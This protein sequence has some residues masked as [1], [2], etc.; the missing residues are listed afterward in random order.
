MHDSGRLVNPMLAEG[1]VVGGGAQGLGIALLEEVAYDP[2]SGRPRAAT[3][4]ADYQLPTARDVPPVVVEHRCTPSEV[5]PGGYRGV[6][7]GGILPPPATV[8]AAVAAA[9]PEIAA[10]LTATP[11]TPMRIWA[12][13]DAAQRR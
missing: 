6:G 11:L 10:E 4:P 12:A 13:W 2:D 3:S 9:V 1:Q 8:A 7:E 5:I